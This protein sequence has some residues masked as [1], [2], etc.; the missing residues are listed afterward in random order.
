MSLRFNP[1]YK[2]SD[3]VGASSL[4]IAALTFALSQ[5]SAARI[6]QREYSNSVRGAAIEQATVLRRVKNEIVLVFETA[7]IAASKADDALADKKDP[8]LA[9]AYLYQSIDSARFPAMAKIREQPSAITYASVYGYSRCTGMAYD[10]AVSGMTLAASRALHALVDSAE[11]IARTQQPNTRNQF[12]RGV[13]T[14]SLRSR[15]AQLG[16][17]FNHEVD[18]IKGPAERAL[19]QLATASDDEIVSHDSDLDEDA[20]CQA[21]RHSYLRTPPQNEFRRQ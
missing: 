11:A 18:S 7:Q 19:T 1:E 17:R 5:L 10:S 3:V 4:A 2:V 20:L 9:G 21:F 14:R 6:R 8:A 15:I 13:L 12:A 16:A